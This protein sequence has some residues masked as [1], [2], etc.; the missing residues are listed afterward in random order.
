M[1]STNRNL[2]FWLRLAGYVAVVAMIA[3]GMLRLRQSIIADYSTPEAGAAWQSWRNDVEKKQSNLGDVEHRE[4]RAQE[5]PALVW[6]RDYFFISLTG[7]IFFI[8]L[9]YWV[10]VWMLTGALQGSSIPA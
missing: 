4:V 8:S 9:L 1:S 6:M 5:P 3:T 10:L 7:A 2:W